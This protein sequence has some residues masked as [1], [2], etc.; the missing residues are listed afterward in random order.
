MNEPKA[1][2]KQFGR[3][4]PAMT[5]EAEDAARARLRQAIIESAGPR[6]DARRMAG[7]AWRLAGAGGFA[8]TLAAGV[9]VAHR[10]GTDHQHP[11]AGST[12]HVA[13]LA[14]VQDLVNKAARVTA[15]Q[16]YVAPRPHQWVYDKTVN[17]EV[18]SL[19]NPKLSLGPSLETWA[20]GDSKMVADY[21][22]M[23]ARAHPGKLKTYP[24][25]G[26]DHI[27]LSTVPTDQRRLLA[28]AYAYTKKSGQ[29]IMPGFSDDGLAFQNLETLLSMQPPPRLRSAVFRALGVIPGVKTVGDVTD[30]AGRRGIALGIDQPGRQQRL[31]IILD[32]H[33]YLYLGDRD[34]MLDG[35]DLGLKAGTVYAVSAATAHAIVDKEGQRP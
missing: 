20:R 14:N 16:P 23:D 2:I 32:P 21:T 8:L 19:T 5:Q 26:S 34:V 28:W 1:P 25:S 3:L 9:V 15:T 33:T 12:L 4:V 27:D 29:K 24:T 18:T 22:P 31:E 10:A 13:P 7:P 17:L 6:R 11:G 30:A 35:N